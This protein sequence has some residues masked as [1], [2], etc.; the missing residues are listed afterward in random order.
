MAKG[1]KG[2]CC[3]MLRCGFC[4]TIVL[5]VTLAA[6]FFLPFA[7]VLACFLVTGR[8]DST[9]D[10]FTLETFRKISPAEMKQVSGATRF[11]RPE[12]YFQDGFELTDEQKQQYSA[13]GYVILRNVLPA[14]TV[15]DLLK[16]MSEFLA[17]PAE[18]AEGNIW[19]INDAMFDFCKFSPLGYIASQLLG[20]SVTHLM[21][22]WYHL[23]KPGMGPLFPT[24]HYD[25]IE[26]EDGYP[27]AHLP[28]RT[29][30]KFYVSLYDQMEAFWI[31]NQTSWETLMS[32]GNQTELKMFKE[33]T[34][35]AFPLHIFSDVGHEKAGK[36]M[37]EWR[38][39]PILNRGDIIVHSPCIFHMSPLTT[40]G[41][42]TGFV[43][44]SYA[45]SDTHYV[46]RVGKRQ[47]D[48]GLDPMQYS[49]ANVSKAPAMDSVPKPECYPKVFPVDRSIVESHAAFRY[50]YEFFETLVSWQHNNWRY[51]LME[52]VKRMAGS[53]DEVKKEKEEL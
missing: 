23:K 44:P 43:G 15:E 16:E 31:L 42:M 19:M 40:K 17:Y 3:C 11:A 33:G 51:V 14:S 38:I 10:M 47:C 37:T 49:Q 52:S 8:W 25:G 53:P 48:S 4:S 7:P 24:P 39:E 13:D 27:P 32:L 36:L 12:M 26:C 28:K 1:F 22:A 20:G 6:L 18:V 21:R 2:C 41:K 9:P 29:M 35:P 50:D 46:G 34:L 45:A 30:V 5:A